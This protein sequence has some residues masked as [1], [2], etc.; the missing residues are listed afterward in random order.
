MTEIQNPKLLLLII[1][2]FHICSGYW[3]RALGNFAF[4]E[5]AEGR[6]PQGEHLQLI[7]SLVPGIWDFELRRGK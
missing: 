3:L 4:G 6:I 7:R 1:K 5:P 2:A